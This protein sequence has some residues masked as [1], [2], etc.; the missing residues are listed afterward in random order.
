MDV[1]TGKPFIDESIY[2]TEATFV[3]GTKKKW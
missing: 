1:T 2:Y 3:T